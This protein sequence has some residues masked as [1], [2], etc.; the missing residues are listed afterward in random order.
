MKR[1]VAVAISLVLLFLLIQGGIMGIKADDGVWQKVSDFPFSLT[2][3]IFPTEFLIDP[4]NPN[5]LVVASFY[6]HSL[7]SWDGG[8]SWSD[9]NNALTTNLYWVDGTWYFNSGGRIYKTQDFKEFETVSDFPNNCIDAFW[10][11]GTTFYVGFRPGDDSENQC[12]YKSTD[13]GKTWQNLSSSI[14]QAVGKDYPYYLGVNRITV[15]KGLVI[16]NPFKMK[17]EKETSDPFINFDTPYLFISF[18]GGLT[19]QKLNFPWAIEVLI[20]GDYL[21]IESEDLPT[22]LITIYQSK[23]GINWEVVVVEKSSYYLSNVCFDEHTGVIYGV[24]SLTGV[25]YS[26]NGGKSWRP[27]NQG[28]TKD[29]LGHRNGTPILR[30]CNNKL[31]LVMPGTPGGLYMNSLPTVIILQIG[32]PYMTLNGVSQEIDPGRG[33]KPV[34]KNSRTLLPITAVIEALNGTVGWD[35]TEKKVAVS[36]GSTNIELWIGKST[37]KVNDVDTPIDSTN[38][39]VVPEIINSRT[40]LPLRF[41]TENLGCKVD[42]E[43]STQTITITYPMR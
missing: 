14:R 20:V 41:I 43:P 37:A 12:F 13:G 5:H 3:Y 8:V 24:N 34:I 28:F 6:E 36:V 38:S 42:W 32:N 7:Q 1:F 39:K 33:T 19:F 40:M 18:D 26:Q 11:D 2:G 17:G 10:T 23:D 9:A 31:Y 22:K 21:W 30:M 29:D 35:A 16:T 25:H 15:F 4:L 27:Y